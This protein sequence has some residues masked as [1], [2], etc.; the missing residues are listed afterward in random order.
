[1]VWLCAYRLHRSGE[2]EDAFP[3]FRQLIGA[4]RI[5][6]TREDY[7]ALF[8]DRG[9][10]FAETAQQDA[11]ALLALA[12]SE[13]GTE[14]VGILGGE[15]RTGVIVEVVETLEETYV[16]FSVG[17]MDPTRPVIILRAF[18]SDVA[19]NEWELVD[20][21]PTRPLRVDQGEIAYRLLRG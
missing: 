4:G 5:I 18:Y 8:E 3:Y 9:N 13:P 20:R 10:R 11:Q 16:A 1:V 14:H 2:P 6:P 17:R 7:R 12:R 19:F 21:L 15:E